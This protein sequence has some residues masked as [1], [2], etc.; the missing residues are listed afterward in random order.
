MTR[1]SGRR[2]FRKG[3]GTHTVQILKNGVSQRTYKVRTR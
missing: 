3:T 1:T 2:R